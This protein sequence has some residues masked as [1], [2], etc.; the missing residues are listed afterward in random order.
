[1]GRSWFVLKML[2]WER[3][4]GTRFSTAVA[5]QS[6]MVFI[7]EEFQ[8]TKLSYLS[9]AMRDEINELRLY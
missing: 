3:E 8:P 4:Y 5:R 6:V 9:V 1:M 2:G 7:D